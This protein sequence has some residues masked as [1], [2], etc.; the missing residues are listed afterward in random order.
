M[1]D[2]SL[3]S[4]IDRMNHTLRSKTNYMLSNMENNSDRKLV[5][6]LNLYV[7][8]AHVLHYFKPWLVG[9]VSLRM[10]ELTLKIGL[11][12]QTPLV[13]VHFGGV[14]VTS[15]YIPEGCRLGELH[16]KGNCSD[17]CVFIFL[18]IVEILIFN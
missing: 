16:T 8:L 13:F 10:V 12:A 3:G 1:K 11:S 5:A 18:L 6:L 17:F 9:S 14:L 4:D 15:G 2:N 7:Y